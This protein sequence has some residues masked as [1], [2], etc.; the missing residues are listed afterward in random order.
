MNEK[1]FEEKFIVFN[2]KD[3]KYLTKEANYTLGVIDK[4]IQL[5]RVSDNKKQINK[6]YVCNQDE[7]YAQAII[8]IILTDGQWIEQQIKDARIDENKNWIEFFTPTKFDRYTKDDLVP[9]ENRVEELK[10]KRSIE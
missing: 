2:H 6:Y 7:S 5:G 3:L 10:N 9:F 1:E 8:D 4:A